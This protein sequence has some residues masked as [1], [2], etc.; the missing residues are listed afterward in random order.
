MLEI[1]HLVVNGCSFT[2]CQGLDNPQIN[3]WPALLAN[4]LNVPVVNLAALGSGCDGIYRRTME[5]FHKNLSTNS[6]PFYII[7]W[8][9]ATRR[10]EFL[11]INRSNPEFND[12]CNLHVL[13]P[14]TTLERELSYQFSSYETVKAAE[15]R[16]YNYWAGILN[17]LQNHKVPYFM[18]DAIPCDYIIKEYLENEYTEIYNFCVNDK[19]KI[20]DHETILTND[21]WLPCGHFNEKANRIWA[22]YIYNE[23]IKLYPDYTI[24][25]SDYLKLI[26]FPVDKTN[27]NNNKW[28]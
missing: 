3:G 18:T 7:S 10:E 9:A 24:I 17:L 20:V 26:D 8:S 6:K 27:W 28:K 1:S 12:Y 5:Y 19:Y 23:F 22:D 21:C 14:T 15:K 4:K 13:R 11:A 16:K 25:Q 2:Y